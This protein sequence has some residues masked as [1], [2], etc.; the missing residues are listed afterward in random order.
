MF[1]LWHTSRHQPIAVIGGRYRSR[2]DNLLPGT[3]EADRVT[4]C[5]QEQLRAV[6]ADKMPGTKSDDDGLQHS[7]S[8]L[9]RVVTPCYC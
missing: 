8:F 5:A 9:A 1:F 7:R 2:A 6:H 3:V 4:P